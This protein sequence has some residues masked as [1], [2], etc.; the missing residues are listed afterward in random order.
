M[1]DYRI[2]TLKQDRFSTQGQTRPLKSI[3]PSNAEPLEGA[4]FL[5][6]HPRDSLRRWSS[7]TEIRTISAERA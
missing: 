1:E 6:E 4:L 2:K 5:P 3:L 7:E